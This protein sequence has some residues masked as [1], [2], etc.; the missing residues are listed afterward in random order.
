MY[1]W[2][3]L[4]HKRKPKELADMQLTQSTN[5]R[6]SKPLNKYITNFSESRKPAS[7]MNL[8]SISLR[9]INR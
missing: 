6:I 5:Q 8:W 1:K 4:R 7:E 9:K 2:N 3:I